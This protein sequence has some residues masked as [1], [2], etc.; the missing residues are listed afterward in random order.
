MNYPVIVQRNSAEEY[1]AEPLGKP[2]L[3]ATAPTEAE[4]LTQVGRALGKWLGSS[5]IVELEVPADV[6]ENSWLAAWGRSADDPDFE[7]YVAEIERARV[8]DAPS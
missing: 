7:E 4:A 3:K 2:E 6:S 5:K 8:A 1:I